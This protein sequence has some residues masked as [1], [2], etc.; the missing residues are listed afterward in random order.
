MNAVVLSHKKIG[1]IF[2]LRCL[3]S[4]PNI[5]AYSEMFRKW[6]SNVEKTEGNMHFYHFFDGSERE[7]L[8]WLF[9]NGTTTFLLRYNNSNQNIINAIKDMQLPII[10]HCRRNKLK[11]AISLYLPGK[12]QGIVNKTPQEILDKV[13]QLENF[14]KNFDDIF[15]DSNILKIYYE[16]MIGISNKKVTYLNKK[17]SR[18]ICE[19][20]NIDIFQMFA[21]KG[22][23]TKKQK[24]ENIWDYLDNKKDTI[25]I[26]K[27]ANREKYLK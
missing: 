15:K 16:D 5:H 26:F 22:K 13:I 1:S 10:H 7:Y 23:Q 8:E 2:F 9:M 27:K 24:S 12:D 6:P 19:F 14:E 25:K 18:D 21:L 20:L 4:H 3:Q 11:H 17:V